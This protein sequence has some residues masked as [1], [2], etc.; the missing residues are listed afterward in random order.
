M[1]EE[2]PTSEEYLREVRKQS[3]EIEVLRRVEIKRQA[4]AAWRNSK[5]GRILGSIY[6]IVSVISI[7]IYWKSFGIN[8]LLSIFLGIVTW[9]VMV[10]ILDRLA[11]KMS[12]I[13]RKMFKL[14]E[15]EMENYLE[16]MKGAGMIK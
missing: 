7:F 8:I 16:K 11:I 3:P 1:N 6:S 14:S 12:G 5:S 13:E 10:S 15:K 4:S 2:K 9:A